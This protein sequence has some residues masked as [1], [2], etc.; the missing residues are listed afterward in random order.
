MTVLLKFCQFRFISKLNKDEIYWKLLNT[1][2]ALDFRK[3][4]QRWTMSELARAS[5]VKRPLIYYYFGKSKIE[6]LSEAVRL[7]G[8]EFFGLSKKR[9]SLWESGQIS[10]S[11]RQTRMIADRAPYLGAFYLAHREKDTRLGEL[12]RKLEQDQFKKIKRFFP[13]KTDEEIKLIW[14]ML[15]GLVFSPHLSEATIDLAFQ[16]SYWRI[17]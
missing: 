9:V 1:V 6:I 2:I 12:I 5:G 17:E 8:E 15:F 7:L 3:G 14:G 13:K 10:A 11:V 4:H 16:S